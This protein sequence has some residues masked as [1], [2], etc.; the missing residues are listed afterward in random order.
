MSYSM[1]QHWHTSFVLTL[2]KALKAAAGFVL[3]YL[4]QIPSMT[5]ISYCLFI[6]S[7]NAVHSDACLQYTVKIAHPVST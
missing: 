3:G 7:L 6:C 4:N 5:E 1:N 2:N